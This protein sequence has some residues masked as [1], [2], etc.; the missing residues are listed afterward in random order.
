MRGHSERPARADAVPSRLGRR[1]ALL[2]GAVGGVVAL[3]LSVPAQPA[4]PP[5]APPIAAA[6]DGQRAYALA[7]TLAERFPYRITGSAADRAAADWMAAQ[8]AALGLAVEQQAF[9][10]WGTWGREPPVV[11]AGLNVLAV[12]PGR[13]RAA[14]VLGAHRDVAPTT[15]Q[16]AE[17]NA[18]GSGALLELA[19]VLHATPHRLT[20]VFVSFG[21]EETGLGGSRHYLA[22]ARWPTAATVSL[23][24]VGRAGGERLALSDFASLPRPAAWDLVA[25]GQALGLLAEG[26]ERPP[27]ALVGV[28]IPLAGATDSLPFAARGFPAVGLGW[29]TPA[30]PLHTPDDTVERL[31]PDSL[32]R[33]GAL[34]EQWVRALDADPALLAEPAPYL[35]YADG[36]Y[37]APAQ[38]T[39]AAG[40][41]LLGAGAQLGLAAWLAGH[42]AVRRAAARGL[43]S[44]VW[45]A[46]AASGGVVLVAAAAGLPLLA[47]P[48]GRDLTAGE[49]LVWSLGWALLVL[50]PRWIGHPVAPAGAAARAGLLAAAS[51]SYL[52]FAALRDPFFALLAAGYPLVAWGVLAPGRSGAWGLVAG[53]WALVAWGGALLALAGRVYLPELVPPGEAAC[54]VALLVLPL[55]A[56]AAA[57]R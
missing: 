25:R 55:A 34:A 49:L 53:P 56:V 13:E 10:T 1:V 28:P 41:L 33:V 21:A 12:S 46:G 50:A 36:R 2:W 51:L 18:S 52:G 20:Y 15:I 24:A 30:Y 42:W 48:A 26:P 22:T 57:T 3:L 40:A 27:A 35:R 5:H 7:R 44:T 8:F 43:A 19:R 29:A 9:T 11:H 38:V 45:R 16:G 37:I 4:P 39:A 32:A 23:D 6:F 31:A 47:R 14:V 17:D 54:A